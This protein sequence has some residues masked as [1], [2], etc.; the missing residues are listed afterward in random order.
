MLVQEGLCLL[1][2][3]KEY[4]MWEFGVV[5]LGPSFIFD[6]LHSGRKVPSYMS[7]MCMFLYI[8]VIVCRQVFLLKTIK[9]THL[10]FQ[11]S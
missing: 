4:F 5:F 9:K 2:Y 3:A 6:T 10:S 11:T 8:N 1:L 7:M